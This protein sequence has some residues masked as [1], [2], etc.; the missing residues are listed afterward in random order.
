MA[1]AKK[2]GP[3]IPQL[4]KAKLEADIRKTEAEIKTQEHMADFYQVQAEKL[5]RQLWIDGAAWHNQRIYDFIGEVTRES[6]MEAIDVL[7][8]WSF[9]SK[10]PI[11]IRIHSEGGSV[12]SGFA[13]Y[14]FILALRN[15]GIVV[16]T[17]AQAYA[18]S[19]GGILLQAGQTRYVSPSSQ[20]LIHE[21]AYGTGFDKVSVNDDYIAYVKRLQDRCL[22]ILASRSTLPK[23]EIAERW[24]KT[25][26][27]LTAEEMVEYGFADEISYY[28]E[29][30]KR[31]RRRSA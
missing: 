14:D 18:A 1:E 10:K 3:T 17:M 11:T 27:W 20:H 13:L 29:G 28:P 30:S 22:D 5:A 21:V 2:R 16:N 15:Q 19:M 4:Q 23:D 8:I 6:V 12:V 25:D 31:G 24:R 7:S 26:W 9:Q